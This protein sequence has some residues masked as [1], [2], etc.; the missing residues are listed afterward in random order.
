MERNLRLVTGL[1]LFAYAASHFLGHATGLFGLAVMD[2][3][4]ANIILAPW[5]TIVGRAVL[6]LSFLVHGALGLRALYRRRHLKAPALEAWQLGLGLLIP[7]LLVPHVVDVRVGNAIYDLDDTY[8]RILYRIWIVNSATS[9]PQQLVLLALV[10]AHGCIGLNFWLRRR[11]WFHRARYF[12]LAG[13]VAIPLI[14]VLGIVNAGWDEAMAAKTQ[15]EFAAAHALVTEG[16]P[17][18]VAQETLGRWA[19]RLQISYLALVA[20]VLMAR[21]ARN[22]WERG[23]H[24]VRITYPG[25]RVVATPPGFSVLE[26]SRWAGIPHA[27]ACGG[28]GRCSTC[29][30]EILTGAENTPERSAAEAETLMRVRAPSTVR[31]ACQLRPTGD[32]TIA[33]LVAIADHARDVQIA[34]GESHE[35]LVTAMF[36]DLRDST[37]FAAGRLPFDALFVIDRYV[38]RA[39]AAIEAHGGE[40]TSVAGDGI[41]SLFG[42]RSD[43]RAGARDALRAIGA[44]WDAIDGISRDLA[45]ELE[46]PLG[47]GVGV[48]A[49]LAA[50]WAAEMLG[51]S[52]LQFLGEAGN[53]AARL[54]AATKELKCV[55]LV[56]EAV[57]KTA[58]T[59][60]PHGLAR[61]ELAIRGLDS[62]TFRVAIMREREQ[63]NF[64]NAGSATERGEA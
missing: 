19:K 55:C 3:V 2:S 16:S 23:K 21:A 44:I 28:R 50:V 15:P 26:A 58:G 13:A 35:R 37:Q 62:A 4:G 60:V 10:W 57:F 31:L 47:F 63:A 61:E 22:R 49:S 18:G 24:S 59:L 53:V 38:Q 41:M 17:Q 20:L 30:V 36:I 1:T 48:H 12:L 6:L 64:E 45:G 52:S 29:R 39:S 46:R 33:P 40:V 25:G 34:D 54:E 14:S 27:S 43:S 51:R 56:S 32:I 5:Q 7:L 42:A 8:Y 9:L 11:E